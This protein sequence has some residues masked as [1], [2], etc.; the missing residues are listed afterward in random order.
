MNGIILSYE[1]GNL[2]NELGLGIAGSYE[3]MSIFILL[4]V[5][6]ISYLFGREIFALL[7]T[8]LT[9]IGMSI[10]NSE[11]NTFLLALVA[12]VF[13]VLIVMLIY[14]ITNK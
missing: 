11:F 3:V 9:A 4:L 5:F 2:I 14:R 7:A 13:G 6:I 12:V 1:I 10:W 8:S